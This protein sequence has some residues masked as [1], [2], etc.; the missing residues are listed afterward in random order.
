MLADF[1]NTLLIVLNAGLMSLFDYLAAHILLC[2]VPTFIIAACMS[3]MI[4]KETTTRI[5]GP[6]TRKWI[7]YQETAIG[8]FFLA[9]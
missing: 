7:S 6:W 2:L 5:L 3:A 9:G 4:P 1:L 8:G